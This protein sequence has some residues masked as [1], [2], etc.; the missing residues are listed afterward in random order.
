MYYLSLSG[1]V[2]CVFDS[3]SVTSGWTNSLEVCPCNVVLLP[4]SVLRSDGWRTIEAVAGRSEKH[5]L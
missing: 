2:S 4:V 3:L 5:K 1:S